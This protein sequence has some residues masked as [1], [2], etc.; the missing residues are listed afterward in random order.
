MALRRSGVRLPLSPP[1]EKVRSAQWYHLYGGAATCDDS[2]AFYL[3][4]LEAELPVAWSPS[5][6]C[7]RIDHNLVFKFLKHDVERKHAQQTVPKTP[8]QRKGRWHFEN[9]IHPQKNLAD[10]TRPKPRLARIVIVALG[11]KLRFGVRMELIRFH[12]YLANARLK[13]SFPFTSATRPSAT[14]RRRRAI[15]ASQA[16]DMSADTKP[17]SSDWTAANPSTDSMPICVLTVLMS[18]T[19]AMTPRIIPKFG[20]TFHCVFPIA[21]NRALA[22]YRRTMTLKLW[23]RC[24]YRHGYARGRQKAAP[25][26]QPSQPSREQAASS[27]RKIAQDCRT[28]CR[29][30]TPLYTR[31]AR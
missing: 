21:E 22:F 9:V 20:C 1:L 5:R 15:S 2:F 13:T 27:R 6:M 3:K 14:S 4:S 25:L 28:P 24:N 19:C 7:N 11:K 16:S 26:P 8:S 30:P 12:A 23:L 17:S 10:K 31:T 29:P 18:N